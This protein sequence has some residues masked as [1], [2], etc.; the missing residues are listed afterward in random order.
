MSLQKV[1]ADSVYNAIV[2]IRKMGKRDSAD[3]IIEITGG[4]KGTVLKLRREAYQRLKEE[5]FAD[6]PTA[7]FVS[8]TDPLVRKLWTV[9]RQ[10][11]ELAAS[12]QVEIL[13]AN[14]ATLE[15]DVERLADWEERAAKAERRVA[16]LEAQNNSLNSQL[17]DLVTALAE[18]KSR[19]ETPTKSEIGAVLR[20]VRALKRR[21]THDEL[22]QEMQ[23][24][25]WSA[26]AAQKAR[27]RVMAAGYLEPAMEISDK[28]QSWLQ[29]NLQP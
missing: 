8:V 1:T 28:G 7:G 13:S 15:D 27:F 22:Y 17:L 16:E 18:G 11:A 2:S 12:R 3:A 10:Q 20:A 26:P 5:G 4:S 19:K 23:G 29:K 21:P 6:D 14:I 25:I 24:P 9:A